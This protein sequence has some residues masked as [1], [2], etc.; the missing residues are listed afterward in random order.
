[1]P[2]R[3]CGSNPVSAWAHRKR[4][5]ARCPR[6]ATN[7]ATPAALRGGAPLV[8]LRGRARLLAVSWSAKALP[9][10]ADATNGALAI[11][12]PIPGVR[13]ACPRSSTDGLTT[14][15]RHTVVDRARPDACA[16]S[17]SAPGLPRGGSGAH[18]NG[19]ATAG[20]HAAPGAR[21]EAQAELGFT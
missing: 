16:R 21:S 4:S 6:Q 10:S 7:K 2:V 3:R 13:G 15:W 8:Q 19:R 1:M 17:A 9:F 20:G 18:S 11:V 14:A 12:Q 5:S